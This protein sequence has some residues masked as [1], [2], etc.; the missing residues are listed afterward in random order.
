MDTTMEMIR[1]KF[2]ALKPIMDER[3]TRLWAGAEADALGP[4]GIAMVEE[5]TGLSRTTIRVGRDE[6]RAGV[7]RFDIVNVRQPGGGRPAIEDK[8]PGIIDALESLV[9]PVT[10]GD[11]E[12][13]LRWTSKSTRKLADELEQRGYKASPQKVGQL[14][15]ASGYSL[16]STRKTI[17][18]ASH[19]DRDAQFE[20]INDLVDEFHARGAPVISVDTKK[21]EL[22]G[23]FQNS[24]REWQCQGQPV[25]VRVHDFIDDSIGKAI[26]YGV[27]D[28]ANNTGWVNVGIDHD[29]PE[30]AVRSIASWWQHMGKRTYLSATEL[31][32]TA[33]AGGS[34]AARSRLWKLELQRF[35]DRTGLTI[36]VSHFPPGTSKWN[37]IEHRLFCHITENWRGKPLVD[38][39]T[40]VKLIG[41]VRTSTGLIVKAKLDTREYPIG[42]KV[43]DSEMDNLLMTEASF[44]GDWNYTIH[45]RRQP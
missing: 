43:P 35:A 25:P 1:A 8:S 19:P 10:R 11:P 16:Q 23:D 41:S 21:K 9:D 20:F 33:D 34:N 3:M 29:T 44:H 45:P 30:F 4:G 26:P 27:Y 17:E 24:G 36:S 22:V 28:L 31:L 7:D 6:L 18:G 14:L 42:I 32:I 2:I 13:P 12:S 40:V 5:A 39:E 38:Y 15:H 37:K